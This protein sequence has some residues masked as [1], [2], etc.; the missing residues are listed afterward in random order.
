MPIECGICKKAVNE[1][2]E[3]WIKCGKKT[4]DKTFHIGCVNV[5]ESDYEKYKGNNGEDWFCGDCDKKR[6]SDDKCSQCLKLIG[7]DETQIKCTGFNCNRVY[8]LHC[9]GYKKLL[10]SANSRRW[11]CNHCFDRLKCRVCDRPFKRRDKRIMCTGRCKRYYHISC[12]D[13]PIADFEQQWKDKE[14]TWVCFPCTQSADE[15]EEELDEATKL[16]RENEALREEL[17][18]INEVLVCL[19]SELVEQRRLVKEAEEEVLNLSEAVLVKDEELLELHEFC[20][21]IGVPSCGTKKTTPSTS[22]SGNANMTSQIPILRNDL[23]H[24]AN[25]Y[26]KDKKRDKNRKGN[27]DGD[28]NKNIVITTSGSHRQSRKQ[29][30][31]SR[32]SRRNAAN[33]NY[34]NN[35]SSEVLLKMPS[36]TVVLHVESGN[37]SC[38]SLNDTLYISFM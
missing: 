24:T 31:A 34:N 5:T 17:R 22:V 37:D 25:K 4:C 7:I 6:R 18:S 14:D 2:T 32:H 12:L 21:G 29:R 9:S 20:K 8:H 19:S 27:N 1:E 30:Y 38:V 16:K 36:E 13:I 26:E 35:G 23:R 28:I 3:K 15:D 10:G 11:E 33:D